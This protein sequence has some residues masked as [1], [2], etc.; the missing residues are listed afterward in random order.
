M[1]FLTEDYVDPKIE[2]NM[3]GH[4]QDRNARMIRNE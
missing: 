4:R 1:E 2:G 3:G